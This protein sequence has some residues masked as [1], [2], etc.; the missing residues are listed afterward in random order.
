VKAGDFVQY[1]VAAY[2][3]IDLSGLDTIAGGQG[4]LRFHL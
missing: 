1:R 4:V 3:A 2:V